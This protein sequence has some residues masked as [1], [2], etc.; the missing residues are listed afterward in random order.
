MKVKLNHKQIRRI[1]ARQ[2]MSVSCIYNRIARE[3]T[4]DEIEQG[5]RVSE[6]P[7]H[8]PLESRYDLSSGQTS[9]TVMLFDIIKSITKLDDLDCYPLTVSVFYGLL[10]RKQL[11]CQSM[12]SN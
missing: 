6:R 4:M 8:K 1:A 3:W 11:L 9:F 2:T 7:Y 12:L 5:F 10:E